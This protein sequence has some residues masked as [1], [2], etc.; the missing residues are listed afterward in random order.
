MK[1]LIQVTI[2][3][4]RGKYRKLQSDL[5]KGRETH[6]LLSKEAQQSKKILFSQQREKKKNPVLHQTTLNNKIHLFN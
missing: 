4:L 2:K 6:N 3:D 5:S 1:Y